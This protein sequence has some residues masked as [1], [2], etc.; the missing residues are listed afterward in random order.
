MSRQVTLFQGTGS[1][2]ELKSDELFKLVK[3]RLIQ[4]QGSWAKWQKVKRFYI[5]DLFCGEGTNIVDD[6]TILGSPL[7]SLN[8]IKSCKLPD[9]IEQLGL[10]LS[11]V[12]PEALDVLDAE[13]KTEFI[14]KNVKVHLQNITAKNALP[15]I[16]GFLSNKKDFHAILILD[17]NGPAAI[18]LEELDEFSRIHGGHSDIILNFNITAFKRVFGHRN[19]KGKDSYNDWWAS[20]VEDVDDFVNIVSK[21]YNGTW[22][23]KNRPGLGGW[24]ILC[25]FG[26]SQPSHWKKQGYFPYEQVRQ[27]WITK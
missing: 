27:S 14:P 26:Y 3:M 20:W 17:P 5:F 13:L 1:V 16:T 21:H 19:G 25:C 10:Y 18:P 22:M 7:C 9:M 8:A 11:D 4:N 12:R 2:T 24:S 6:K 15:V 23:R